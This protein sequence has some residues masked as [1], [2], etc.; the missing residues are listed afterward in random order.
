M[1][2]QSFIGLHREM[3]TRCKGNSDAAVTYLEVL[4]ERLVVQSGQRVEH[5]KPGLS[6]RT[7]ANGKIAT[8]SQPSLSSLARMHSSSH[9]VLGY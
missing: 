9:A 3:R 2:S 1:P 4:E 5:V 8:T 6:T 7:H